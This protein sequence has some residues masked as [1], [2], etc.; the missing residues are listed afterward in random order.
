[1]YCDGPRAVQHARGLRAL[2]VRGE[3]GI[4]VLRAIGDADERE[5]DARCVRRVPGDGV[6]VVRH[7]HAVDRRSAAA[8][9][10]ALIDR[11]CDLRT[12]TRAQQNQR[13][14]D[15]ARHGAND[16][17]AP[18]TGS[19]VEPCGCSP[20]TWGSVPHHGHADWRASAHQTPIVTKDLRP[21][22]GQAISEPW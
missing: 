8:H 7:V 21:K 17:W 14:K 3:L 9:G 5:V 12:G 22:S 2:P 10:R 6:V 1:M 18:L 19:M 16:T 11:G 4:L 15:P 20:P 13:K